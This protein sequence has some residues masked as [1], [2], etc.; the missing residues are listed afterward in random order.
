LRLGVA[1]L[2]ALA[3][4][5]AA[6]NGPA[7]RWYVQVDN[8]VIF[9]TDR[10]Y[11]SGVR[12]ARASASGPILSEWGL[13]HEVFTPEAKGWSP[14]VD[15]R[16]PSAR[17]LAYGARHW[18]D[19]DSFSTF[20]A[21]LGV[22]GRSALGEQATEAIHRLVPAP[23]VDWS[24]QESDQVDAQLALVRSQ[25]LS[26]FY[27]HLGAVAGN[28]QVF[29]H[30]GVEWRVGP[31]S[32]RAALSP[33]MRYAA[34]PPPAAGECGW[35]AFAG[36]SVRA[37]ARNQM[38]RRNYDPFG[39]QL[40]PRHAVGRAVLGINTVQD[41]GSATLALV[42]DTREFDAQRRPHAFGSLTV[43]LEF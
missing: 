30:A 20:E 26:D 4:T 22:R 2:L 3:A 8:D 9:G 32:T 19:P 33:A 12:I 40:E 23:E 14:G 25:R 34:T 13:L 29:G 10:W 15:D 1:V 35:G 28:Q 41:W 7:P 24:R 16:A 17:L 11:T 21:A 39:A 43:H 27:L 18:T 5:G 31:P 42:Q 38:I 36:A 37:V 6:A